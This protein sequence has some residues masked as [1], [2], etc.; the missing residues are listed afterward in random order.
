MC[1]GLAVVAEKVNDE[2]IV[3]A[4]EGVTS[5]DELIHTLRDDLRCGTSP[6]IKF[7]IYFPMIINDDIQQ[8][9]AEKYYPKGWVEN[10]FGRWSACPESIA[11]VAQYLVD[12]K[13]LLNFDPKMLQHASLDGASLD[14]ASLDGAS[15]DGAS[16]NRAS[17]NRASLNRASLD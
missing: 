1:Q 3:Y 10:K 13:D 5:H 15:L 4:K 7:E 17:L 8:D 6:Q 11:A 14:G 12:N 9:I 16:L 2:W